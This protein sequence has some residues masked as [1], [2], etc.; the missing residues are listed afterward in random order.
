[1]TLLFFVMMMPQSPIFLTTDQS[2]FLFTSFLGLL[3][4]VWWW[5]NKSI[6]LA[7]WLYEIFL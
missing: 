1:M 3:L 4:T 6:T 7:F 2:V 5:A